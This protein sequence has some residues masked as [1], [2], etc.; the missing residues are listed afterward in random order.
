[1]R[2]RWRRPLDYGASWMSVTVNFP[3][4]L[5]TLNFTLSPV[6][7]LSS[8]ALSPTTKT[9]VI[10]GMSRFL[11]SPCL[12]RDLAGFKSILRTSPSVMSA[13]AVAEAAAGCCSPAASDATWDGKRKC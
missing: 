11:M 7:N 12:E 8:M 10:P 4:S 13:A 9:I 6:F 3:A 5:M 2:G 1:M